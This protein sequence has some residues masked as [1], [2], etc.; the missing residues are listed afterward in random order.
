MTC[1]SFSVQAAGSR[2]RD[3]STIWEE[4]RASQLAFLPFARFSPSTCQH[5]VQD[6]S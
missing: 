3:E 2:L 4:E 6:A 5:V 1:S